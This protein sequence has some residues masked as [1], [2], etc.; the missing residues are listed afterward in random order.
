MNPVFRIVLAVLTLLTVLALLGFAVFAL[1]IPHVGLFIVCLM[2]AAG[3]GVFS[4]RDY[5]FFFGGKS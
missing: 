3:F 1:T 5:V 2:L 4:Y